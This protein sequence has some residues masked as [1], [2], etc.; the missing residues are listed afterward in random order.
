MESVRAGLVGGGRIADLNVIGWLEHPSA[1]VAAICDIDPQIR[2]ARAEEWDC[3]PIGSYEDLL[4]DDGIDAVVILTPHHLHAEQA[5]AALEAGKHVSLQKP[6]ARSMAEY[7]TIADAA[8]TAEVKQGAKFQV[9]EDFMFYPP[10]VLAARLV[11]EGEIGDVLSVRLVTA[12][13]RMGHGEGWEVDAASQMWR[14]DPDLCGGGMTTFDHGYHCFNMGRMFVPDPVESVHA[15]INFM[16]MGEYLIDVPSIITWRY[17]GMPRFGSWEVVASLDLDVMSKYYVSDDRMEIRGSKGIIWV[18][19]CC[20][21]LLE[22]P[23]VVL[24]REGEVRS[25][26]RVESDWA[27]SFRDATFDFID[28][29]LDDRPPLQTVDDARET[30]RFALAAQLSAREHR[31]VVPAEVV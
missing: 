22:E 30:L 28:G 12:G 29:I 26:H 20:G 9:F 25:F 31:E 4:A 10:H 11:E 27:A 24:Y 13:G 7:E 14:M 19:Q 15:Y 3:R 16:E 17:A 5:I 6:P 2:D 8:R 1:E 23:P 18:N 21:R